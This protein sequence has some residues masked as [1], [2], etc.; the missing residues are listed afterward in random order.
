MKAPYSGTCLAAGMFAACLSTP[1]PF[2]PRDLRCLGWNHLQLHVSVYSHL[3]GRELTLGLTEISPTL[4][5]LQLGNP[6]Y[7]L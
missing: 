7:L 6:C 1:L 5:H 3:H 4:V 2:L